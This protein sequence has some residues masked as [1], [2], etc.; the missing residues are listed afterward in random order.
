MSGAHPRATNAKRSEPLPG[1]SR[2][3]SRDLE[4]HELSQQPSAIPA[5]IAFHLA[6][7]VTLALV[8]GTMGVALARPQAP[9]VHTTKHL[10]SHESVDHSGRKQTGRASFYAPHFANRRMADGGQ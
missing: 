1:L 2:A 10:G 3:C 6:R 7:A 9:P 8:W 5:M 4:R